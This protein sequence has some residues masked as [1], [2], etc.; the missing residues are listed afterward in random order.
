MRQSSTQAEHAQPTRWS[1]TDSNHH[2]PRNLLLSHVILL[3]SFARWRCLVDQNGGYG[4]GVS[5]RYVRSRRLL[6]LKFSRQRQ[7]SVCVLAADVYYNEVS[8]YSMN[9]LCL[10]LRCL[11]VH[12]QRQ[13]KP[14]EALVCDILNDNVWLPEGGE[15]YV[16]KSLVR[17]CRCRCR[18]RCVMK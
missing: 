11:V 17:R 13:S 14:D 12:L 10:N 9:P 16:V 15:V 6:F 2:S 18:C 5:S 4:R 3:L 8:W 1:W 7:C